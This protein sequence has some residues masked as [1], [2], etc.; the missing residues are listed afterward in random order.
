M[1]DTYIDL[2]GVIL[3]AGKHASA[4]ERL[5]LGQLLVILNNDDAPAR[6]PDI[7]DFLTEL[8][9]VVTF[10]KD[11]KHP[12]HSNEDEKWEDLLHKHQALRRS[13][14]KLP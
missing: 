1:R 13:S 12:H 14:C 10:G 11:H 8:F 2:A 4:E 6:D 9:L 7:V 5:Q 3:E